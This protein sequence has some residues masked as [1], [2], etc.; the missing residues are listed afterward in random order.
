MKP[1]DTAERRRI[2]IRLRSYAPTPRREKETFGA[3]HDGAGKGYLLG[4]L[5]LLLVELDGALE[6]FRR[7]D[8]DFPDDRGDPG[9]IPC[10]TLAPVGAGDERDATFT[11]GA[12]V[13]RR[14]PTELAQTAARASR[15][16]WKFSSQSNV[17]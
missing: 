8:R 13:P 16:V 14:A 11:D 7:F 9:H 15:G 12:P 3:Y 4:P 17:V 10:W 6:A 2:R 1:C 5:D